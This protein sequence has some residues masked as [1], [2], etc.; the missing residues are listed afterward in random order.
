M[1]LRR[2]SYKVVARVEEV[3]DVAQKLEKG[4]MRKAEERIALRW[5]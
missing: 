4:I 3:F 2:S 5:S 1:N